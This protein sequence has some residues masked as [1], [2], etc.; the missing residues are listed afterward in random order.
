MPYGPPSRKASL[1]WMKMIPVEPLVWSMT[2][3][4]TRCRDVE[5]MARATHGQRRFFRA[6]EGN[7]MMFRGEFVVRDS[8][9][10]LE[11][12]YD[13][14]PRVGAVRICRM[15]EEKARRTVERTF[16]TF[17][18]RLLLVRITRARERA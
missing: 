15:N 1:A 4:K 2:L 9:W 16:M 10:P 3:L 14:W 7:R 12:A 13:M 11:W 8:E 5:Q 6:E 17:F 18:C